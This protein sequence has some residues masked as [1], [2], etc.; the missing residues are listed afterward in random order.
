MKQFDFIKFLAKQREQHHRQNLTAA[1][2]SAEDTIGARPISHI[3]GEVIIHEIA[4]QINR[5]VN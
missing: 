1:A 2:K 5:C 4:C 3:I